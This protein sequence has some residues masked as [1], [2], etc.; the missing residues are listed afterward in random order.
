MAISFPKALAA[1]VRDE[2]KATRASSVSAFIRQA[3]DEKIA[4]DS[5]QQVLDEMDREYGPPT[6][7]ELAWA[8]RILVSPRGECIVV[9]GP[10]EVGTV[11]DDPARRP[12]RD[13]DY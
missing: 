11:G 8:R 10:G 7:E 13:W 6:E 9:D 2:V 12:P 4:R 5:L 1:R 3:V